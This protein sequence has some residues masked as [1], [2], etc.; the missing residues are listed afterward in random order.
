[1]DVIWRVSTSLPTA[2]LLWMNFKVS[3]ALK[4]DCKLHLVLSFSR[5]R[6]MPHISPP[7]W[8]SY[9]K[10]TSH[11]PILVLILLILIQHL[12][13]VNFVITVTPG[14]ATTYTVCACNPA[15]ACSWCK[16]SESW[17]QD[18]LGSDWLS[19]CSKYTKVKDKT[20]TVWLCA[21][22]WVYT[23]SGLLR[24]RTSSSS[25][26][27]PNISGSAA[28]QDLDQIFF[29]WCRSCFWLQ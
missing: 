8:Q 22:A 1:M 29:S 28:D 21:E 12:F 17:C 18:T 20:K 2:L 10:K 14:Q 19:V 24:Q 13:F 23:A 16:R 11:F 9:V 7:D 4:A 3:V 27:V 5:Y 25:L 26:L 15:G 6:L